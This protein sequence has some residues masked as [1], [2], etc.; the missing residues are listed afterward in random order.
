VG[1]CPVAQIASSKLNFTK[2]NQNIQEIS[3]L[4]PVQI[5]PFYS[6]IVRTLTI[7]EGMHPSCCLQKRRDVLTGANRLLFS[8]LALGVDPD[9]RL[10]RGAYP[11]I[12]NQI[13]NSPTSDM[14]DLLRRVLIRPN[15]RIDW[16]RLEQ[17]LTISRAVRSRDYAEL[18]KAQDRSDIRK[19]LLGEQE[20]TTVTLDLA[21]Q[22]VNFLLSDTGAFLREALINE[23]VRSCP[24]FRTAYLGL[25]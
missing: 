5:P 23:L 19:S 15:G 25:S 16:K 8:G 20:E 7:L 17:L 4:L 6:L 22:V 14:R 24:V 11:Y 1:S 10:I 13:L 2:L 21:L 12:A 18:K 3:Y 9:F